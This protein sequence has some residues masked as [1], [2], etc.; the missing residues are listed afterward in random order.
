MREYPKH[1]KHKLR[2]LA[3]LVR[4]RDLH[5]ELVRLD[6]FFVQWRGGDLTDQT[7]SEH[8]Y[9][10]VVGPLR[11]MNRPDTYAETDVIVASHFVAGVLTPSEVG[12]D[13]REALKGMIERFQADYERQRRGAP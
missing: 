10:F 11:E 7:L 1:I 5:Q 13:V 2:E 3:D 8:L 6:E 4:Q 9:A 12:E